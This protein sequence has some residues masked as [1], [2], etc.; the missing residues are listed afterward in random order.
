MLPSVEVRRRTWPPTV[1]DT[2]EW[3]EAWSRATI[4]RVRAT[5]RAGPPLYLLEYSPFWRGYEIDTGLE[6]VWDSPLVT[7]GTVY[8]FYGPAY[9]ADD[10][11]SVGA[12]VD[13]AK[14]RAVTWDAAG[15]LVMNLPRGAADR[16]AK[17]RPP[18]ARVRLDVAYHRPVETGRTPP[19]A[20]ID[21]HVRT[22]WRRRWRRAT[23]RGL[24]LLDEGAPEGH[25]IDEV[26]ALTNGSAEKHGWP[27]IYDRA[28]VDQVLGLPGARLLRAD[29]D[30]RTVGA[31]V[32]L[33]HDRRI[34]LWAGGV[35][36]AVL[37]EVSP[38]LFMLYEV[39]STGAER[40]WER[41]EFGRGS[42]TFKRRHGF[43]GTELWSLWYAARPEAV[44]VYRP[45]LVALHEGLA[46]CMGL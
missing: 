43:A 30:G 38:Y 20:D 3:V 33:E 39:L 45:R 11:D 13:R 19:F 6:P 27:S 14:E 36:H 28:T 16:W 8:S 37:R 26:I 40:G 17:I 10:D 18:D 21:S 32:A 7:V 29:W 5:D 46:H 22:E 4:E 34:Y 31:F 44:P 15:V 1:F 12:V 41:V 2:E 24:R 25:R 42:D 23:E 35:D 9:L